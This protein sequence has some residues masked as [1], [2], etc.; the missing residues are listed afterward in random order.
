MEQHHIA[1]LPFISVKERAQLVRYCAAL[2]G[3][4]EVAEDLAQETLLEAWRNVQALRDP[5]RRSQWLVGIAHNVYLR[6]QLAYSAGN[7]PYV[8][9]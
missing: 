6:W 2:S 9:F 4:S 7:S 5:S 3:E 1:A 8:V